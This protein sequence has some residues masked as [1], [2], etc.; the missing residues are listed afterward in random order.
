MSRGL[1]ILLMSVLLLREKAEGTICPSKT[2]SLFM[3]DYSQRNILEDKP[4]M[5]DC[6]ERCA[7]TNCTGLAFSDLITKSIQF[8]ASLYQKNYLINFDCVR[9]K[10]KLI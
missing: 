8:I 6:F 1:I 4:Y 7:K 9:A 3:I 10:C 5:S 2:T